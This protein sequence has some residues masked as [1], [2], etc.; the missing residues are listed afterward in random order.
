MVVY[1]TSQ[2]KKTLVRDFHEIHQNR[3]KEIRDLSRLIAAI[4]TCIKSRDLEMGYKLHAEAAQSGD[5]SN[6]YVANTLVNMY[7]R[8]GSLTDARR[9]FDRMDRHDL[10]SW[11]VM[12]LGYADS[13]YAELALDLFQLMQADGFGPNSRSFVAAFKACAC[14][15]KQE[16]TA[17]IDGKLV[18]LRALEKGMAL[19]S[20]AAS[21]GCDMDRFVANVLVDCYAN[22]GS[23][24]DSSRVF[25]GIQ[26]PTVVSWTA[27]VLG[28]AENGQGE[29]ALEMFS[30]MQH[31]GAEMDFLSLWRHS[32]LA[33]FWP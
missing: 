17:L 30:Q 18:K 33:V 7:A 10:V 20:Q 24:E 25:Y 11:N 26:S 27:L 2:S 14:L 32:R 15:A 31:E 3:N 19:H 1:S 29:M 28:Y 9:L 5:D 22:C 23:M 8:C 4:K 13:G 6:I 21:F 16:D 12:V